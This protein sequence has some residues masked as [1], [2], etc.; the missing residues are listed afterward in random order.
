L[1]RTKITNLEKIYLSLLFI[2][3]SYPLSWG[4]RRELMQ[5]IRT[6]IEE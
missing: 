4:S 3:T 6:V 1:E 5:K 2:P